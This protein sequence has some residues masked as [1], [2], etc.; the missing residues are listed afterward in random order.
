VQDNTALIDETEEY[1][2]INDWIEKK[3]SGWYKR[4]YSN[5]RE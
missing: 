1:P 2:L 5:L 3:K 4:R